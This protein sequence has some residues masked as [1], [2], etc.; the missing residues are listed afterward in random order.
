MVVLA[1][2]KLI[3]QHPPQKGISTDFTLT[4]VCQCFI[5]IDHFINHADQDSQSLIVQK[6]K[7]VEVNIPECSSGE[8][9]QQGLRDGEATL[10]SSLLTV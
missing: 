9:T 7:E 10:P 5:H 3:Y 4:S 2:G 6:S 8:Q 1:F